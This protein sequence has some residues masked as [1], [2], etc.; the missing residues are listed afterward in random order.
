MNRRKKSNSV[1]YYFWSGAIIFSLLL[2]LFSLIFASASHFDA[3]DETADPDVLTSQGP[4]LDDTP[5]VTQEVPV[6]NDPTV[7]PDSTEAP[8]SS[9]P[10]EL[11]ETEDMGQEYID[12]FIFMGDS[13]TYGLA[14]YN[15]VNRNQVWTP[16]NGT[17]SLFNQ[18]FIRIYYPDTGEELT[19]AEIVSRAQ[20]EYLLITLGVNGIASM[21]ED[22]FK[23]EYISLVETIQANSPNT[24]III[25]SMYPVTATYDT[26]SGISNE[27]IDTGNTWLRDI[28]EST[29]TRFLNSASALKDESGYLPEDGD[30]GD[31]LH[32]TPESLQ[33]VITYIRTHGYQ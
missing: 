32:L 18:S 9:G 30:N 24:K 29:G 15:V 7:P 10:T 21:G 31:G 27:K 5:G 19:V 33:K 4:G 23:S 12:K 3:A 1:F 17:F 8:V 26:S 28:A 2:V 6:I 20:P 25:N 13:T 22:Y 14:V 16:S 11:A